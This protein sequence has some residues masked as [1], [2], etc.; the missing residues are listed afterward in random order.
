VVDETMR[1]I[2]FNPQ[3]D[4]EWGRTVDQFVSFES[5]IGKRYRNDPLGVPGPEQVGVQERFMTLMNTAGDIPVDWN[6]IWDLGFKRNYGELG[7]TPPEPRAPLD[8]DELV[9]GA[10]QPFI[11]HIID[12]DSLVVGTRAGS[13]TFH[14]VRL[15][16]VRARDYGL[17]DEGAVDDKARLM[18]ALQSALSSGDR[19]YL[20]RD[21]D[22]FGS[23]DPYG[24]E[25]AWLWIGDAPFSFP[26]EMLP[27]RDP[28]GGS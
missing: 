21:P 2:A 12:G 5:S 27:N 19:I 3:Y 6:Q 23:V 26:E 13:Q 10:W 17:D 28:S 20:V 24:R 15:I 16:G 25:L 14:E 7:W 4:R 11:R 18:D 22:N 8:E 9:D 1:K